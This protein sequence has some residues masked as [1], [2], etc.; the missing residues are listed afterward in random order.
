MQVVRDGDCW[1]AIWGYFT[2]GLVTNRGFLAPFESLVRNCGEECYG[3]VTVLGGTKLSSR[4]KSTYP[5]M[6]RGGY[7]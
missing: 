7:G 4:M 1:A 3:E 5:W 2:W 6:L